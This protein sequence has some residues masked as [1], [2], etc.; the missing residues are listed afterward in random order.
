VGDPIPPPWIQPE[1]LADK[2]ELASQFLL[3]TVRQGC[4][5]WAGTSQAPPNVIRGASGAHHV[6]AKED[7]VR[8]HSD[9]DMA[10]MGGHWK[11][12]PDQALRVTMKPPPY[13]FVYWGL[14]IVNPWQ[15]SY[16]YRYTSTGWNNGNAARNEDGTWTLVISPEDPGVPNWIDTGGRLEGFALLR[17]VLAGESPP[18]PDCEVVKISDVRAG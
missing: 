15:E 10:Y 4:A 3:F 13:D 17:W 9:S 12:E 6:R 2:L 8:A 14:V 11:L 18:A 7:E 5:M 1:P 16:D